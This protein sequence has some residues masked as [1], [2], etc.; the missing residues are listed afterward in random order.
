MLKT[1]LYWPVLGCL[2]GCDASLYLKMVVAK[3]KWNMSGSIIKIPENSRYELLNRI[4]SELMIIFKVS[5]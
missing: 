4:M 3:N 5:F 1:I 2:D